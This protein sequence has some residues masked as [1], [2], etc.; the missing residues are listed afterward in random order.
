M[1]YPEAGTIGGTAQPQF[2]LFGRLNDA[3]PDAAVA[4][5]VGRC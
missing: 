3:V 2:N 1:S 4:V 5:A